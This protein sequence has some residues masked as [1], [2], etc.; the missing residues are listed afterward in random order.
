[1]AR[2]RT[3]TNFIADIRGRTNQENS[4]FVTDSEITE[5]LN[6]ALAELWGRLT[7]GS[8]QPFYRAQS[9]ISVTAGTS[10][11]SLPADF[12]VLQGIDATING[13]SGTLTPFM[14]AQHGSLNSANRSAWGTVSPVQYRLGGNNIEMLPS[15]MTFTATLYYSPCCPRLVTGSD[16]FDGF[17][18]YE[19]AAVYDACATILAKEESDPGFYI[20]Q[21]DRIYRHIDSLAGDRDM[22]MPERVQDVR[23][24]DYSIGDSGWLR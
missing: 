15:T 12:W 18:G 6:Q 4:L 2:T 20:G 21:R 19:V 11:Y 17:N 7:Q 1:V 13:V 5:Y 14:P 9:P 23:S 16:T 3:L 8:G 24:D 22:S 10:I